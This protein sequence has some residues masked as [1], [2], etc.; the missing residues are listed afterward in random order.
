MVDIDVYNTPS[1]V[2]AITFLA[3]ELAF[4]A[5]TRPNQ[6]KKVLLSANGTI[7]FEHY[8]K[9]PLLNVAINSF[10]QQLAAAY[11]DRDALFSQL[12][13]LFYGTPYAVSLIHRHF[14]LNSGERMVENNRSVKPSFDSSP[15]IVPQIWLRTGQAIEFQYISDPS[16]IAQP[17]SPAFFSTFNSILDRYG[18]DVLG[19]S[20]R[21]DPGRCYTYLEEDGP[22]DRERVVVLI[23]QE[24]VPCNAPEVTWIP[25]Y[26]EN[27]RLIMVACCNCTVNC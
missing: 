4:A 17:P 21:T 16:T 6:P 13:Q 3:K 7:D 1:A 8:N 23:G 26:T 12:A 18:V 25:M 9:L 5:P 27:H 20:Y 24:L 2:D 22:G 14:L 11:I 19:I 10:N 15:N